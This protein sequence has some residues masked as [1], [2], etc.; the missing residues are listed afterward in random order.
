MADLDHFKAV[1]DGY[2]HTVGD[3]V[4]MTAAAALSGAARVTDVVGRYG[5]EEFLVVLPNT[6]LEQ[7]A[8]LAERLRTVLRE[9]RFEFREEPVTC[10]L[11]V[12]EWGED[13]AQSD[14]VAR[15]DAALYAAKR[16]GRDRVERAPGRT[17]HDQTDRKGD[18]ADG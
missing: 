12:A 18:V 4:L 10:S 8:V 6:R 3:Q 17:P 9:Q 16:A 15:A 14:L 2:G 5:G 13:E 7:A 1:D 11:G